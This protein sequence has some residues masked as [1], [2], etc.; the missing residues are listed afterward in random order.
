MLESCTKSTLRQACFSKDDAVTGRSDAARQAAR[1]S[2]LAQAR[3]ALRRCLPDLLIYVHEGPSMPNVRNDQDAME[4]DGHELSKPNPMEMPAG[5]VRAWG[6]TTGNLS[7]L[8]PVM[9]VLDDDLSGTRRSFLRPFHRLQVLGVLT[10]K[11]SKEALG[12]GDE[13]MSR[14]QVESCMVDVLGVLRLS[15]AANFTLRTRVKGSPELLEE[16]S[17]RLHL[18]LAMIEAQEGLEEPVAVHDDDGSAPLRKLRGGAL[19]RPKLFRYQRLGR[20][21]IAKLPISGSKSSLETMPMVTED[22]SALGLASKGQAVAPLRRCGRLS[23][24]NQ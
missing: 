20:E 23:H 18:V 10:M 11:E 13:V 3:A 15:S 22:N 14:Q 17:D 19:G 8:R 9:P 16:A 12:F 1:S 4:E 7:D 24:R 2:A 21:F 6:A 5:W